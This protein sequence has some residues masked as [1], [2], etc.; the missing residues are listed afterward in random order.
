MFKA[1]I[2][3]FFGVIRSDPYKAWLE[4][5]GY[6][7]EDGFLEASNLLDG[8][9]IDFSQFLARVSALSGV[10]S[11]RISDEFKSAAKI[12]YQ[13]LE[14]IKNLKHHYQVGLLS[15]SSSSQIRSILDENNLTDYFN[16]VVVSS[17]VACMKP[18]EEIFNII[19][20]RLNVKPSE[21]LFIDDD[22]SNIQGAETVGIKSVLFETAAQL[23]QALRK[24]NI[25]L[26]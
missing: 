21:V 26:S 18:G 12:E 9:K 20:Q 24:L 25:N 7:R 6:V 4:S 14:L 13:V 1:I 15:N 17:E 11:D 19:L 3:D 2:F 23:E 10:P 22:I 5:H 8:G 16:E